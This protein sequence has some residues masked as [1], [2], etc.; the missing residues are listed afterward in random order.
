[1]PAITT[2]DATVD[3]QIKTLQTEMEAKIKAIREEYQAKI[4][5]AIGDRK[6]SLKNGMGSS[7]MPMTKGDGRQ[8]KGE[9]DERGRGIMMRGSTTPMRHE[10]EMMH[11]SSTEGGYGVMRKEGGNIPN[12]AQVKGEQTGGNGNEGG[13]RGFFGKFFGR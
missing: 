13:V 3:A 1:M 6:A 12:S 4:K 10:G 2:G 9:G 7:T 8:G 5:V 11:G